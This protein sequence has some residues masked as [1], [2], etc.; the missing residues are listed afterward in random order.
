MKKNVNFQQKL[1]EKLV[2][3]TDSQTVPNLLLHVC[4]APCSSYILEYLSSYFRISLFY[5]NPNIAP[6]A[7]FDKRVNELK[8]FT[9]EFPLQNLVT[10]E[11][12]DYRPEEFY[13]M[14]KGLEQEPE[15]GIR[16]YHCY[17]QRLEQTAIKCREGGY[18][19]FTTTLSISPH[20]N[21]LWL[22]EIGERLAQK[23]GVEYLY[24]D[25][26]KRNGYQRSIQLSKE[27][28]LYRQD[29]CGC[30]FSRKEREGESDTK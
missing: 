2:E 15:G 17:E 11:I 16:C 23:Y 28:Q 1:D 30:I 10:I 7:E 19:Y 20:K 8:R 14:A 12:G 3:I 18:D 4:C 24:A 25:F 22:N 29:Y 26:K 13:A 27:Y 9:G 6:K 5:Y 21:A